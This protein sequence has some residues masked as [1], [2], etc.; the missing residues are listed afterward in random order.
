MTNGGRLQLPLLTF[1]GYDN[2]GGGKKEQN[3]DEFIKC[4]FPPPHQRDVWVGMGFL[5]FMQIHY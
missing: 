1:C 3:I 5:K 2:R 4:H